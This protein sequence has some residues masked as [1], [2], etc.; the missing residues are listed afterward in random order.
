MVGAAPLSAE[1]HNQ[2]VALLPNAHV[3]QSYGER[4]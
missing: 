2:L 3:G 1:L 4:I